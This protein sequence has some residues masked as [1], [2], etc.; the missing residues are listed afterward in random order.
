MCQEKYVC[1]HYVDGQQISAIVT[2]DLTW[3]WHKTEW[4][5]PPLSLALETCQSLW[6]SVTTFF[7]YMPASKQDDSVLPE[8]FHRLWDTW[9]G[10]GSVESEDTKV[11]NMGLQHQLQW[12]APCC[13][14][15]SCQE[16]DPACHAGDVAFL[17]ILS[18]ESSH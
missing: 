3:Q 7:P 17:T 12:Y 18:C 1:E 9:R 16:F 15:S 8:P 2:H 14:L 11:Q 6:P 4:G 10:V 13:I 5:Q